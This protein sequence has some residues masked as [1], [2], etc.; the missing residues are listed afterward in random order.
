MNPK[1]LEQLKKKS[2]HHIELNSDLKNNFIQ[3]QLNELNRIAKEKAKR[4]R[5]LIIVIED[6]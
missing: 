6:S 4:K 3:S 2:L 1:E 5:L